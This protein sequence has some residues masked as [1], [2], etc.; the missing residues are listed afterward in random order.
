MEVRPAG[1]RDEW[2]ASWFRDRLSDPTLIDAG[3]V[4]V[5]DGAGYLAVPVGG[6]RRGGYVSASDRGTARCLRDALAG[7]PGYPNVRVRWS[8]CPSDCHTVAWGEAAPDNDDDQAV[9]EFY[10]YSPSAIARFGEESAAAL[11]TN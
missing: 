1:Q 10:G 9:G 3:I 11:R 4:V 7:R 6:Q 5:V 2:E 8:A